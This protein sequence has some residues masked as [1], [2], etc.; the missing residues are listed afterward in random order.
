MMAMQ[1]IVLLVVLAAWGE[2]SG[3]EAV[4]LPDAK[5]SKAA[6]AQEFRFV[7][8]GRIGPGWGR[9]DEIARA[10]FHDDLSALFERTITLNDDVPS[11]T[12]L[13]WIFTGPHAGFTVELTSTKVRVIER[14]YDSMGLYASGNYP[15]KIVRDEERQFIGHA[16]TLTVIADSHLAVRILVNGVRLLDESLQFDVTRH[17]LMYGAP[18]TEHDI[19]AGALLK[20]EVEDATVTIRPQEI[21]QTML[22]FG[23]SAHIS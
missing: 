21:H 4:R 1:K 22:G 9:P 7:S 23:G 10:Y 15:E 3:Q 11:R 19:V 2:L 16:R 13:D 5:A 6:V 18:R 12:R 17:Q 14:Y 20:P 8:D